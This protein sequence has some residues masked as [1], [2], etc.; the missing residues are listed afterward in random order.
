MSWSDSFEASTDAA[1]FCA[2]S[3]FA[4]YVGS[5]GV[6]DAASSTHAADGS[7][8]TTGTSSVSVHFDDADAGAERDA[9][10]GEGVEERRD[11]LD[12]HEVGRG[13]G[14]AEE[15][16]C[17]V[18]EHGAEALARVAAYG[19]FGLAA[20]VGEAAGVHCALVP[21]D[22]GREGAD[23][24]LGRVEL[25]AV[26]RREV[27][28]LGVGRGDDLASGGDELGASTAQPRD[29]GSGGHYFAFVR[30]LPG[31]GRR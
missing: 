10:R 13:A 20:D 25:A 7:D 1:S 5:L 23:F 11:V 29:V 14:G 18:S 4:V 27:A 9:L 8:D 2:T 6:I 24:A 12:G 15:C 28:L 16:A 17:L 19:N 3:V 21:V 30:V 26:G 22:V 31:A